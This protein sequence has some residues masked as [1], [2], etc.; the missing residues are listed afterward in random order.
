MLTENHIG[1]KRTE[2][3]SGQRDAVIN[4][5][6]GDVIAEVASSGAADVAAAVDA[7]SAAFPAWSALTPRSR[8]EILHK[9][10]YVIEENIDE[11]SSLE[12]QNVGKPMSIMEFEMDLTLD[13][14][15]FFASAG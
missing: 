15:R 10:A 2:A 7:A 1:G 4:P 5:A 12:S 3:H 6:T 8:S 11:L 14:W 9:V 13:N